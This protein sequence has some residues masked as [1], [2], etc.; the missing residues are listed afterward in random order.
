MLVTK[1]KKFVCEGCGKESYT[2]GDKC[3]NCELIGKIK[4]IEREYYE[5]FLNG[6]RYGVGSLEYMLEL[7]KDYVV[8]CKMYGKNEADFKIVKRG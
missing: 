5:C 6:K 8:T 2:D 7:F 1:P 3:G 4:P